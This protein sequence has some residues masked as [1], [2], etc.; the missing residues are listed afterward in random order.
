MSKEKYSELLQPARLTNSR[1]R[2]IVDNYFSDRSRI[3]FSPY[4]RT[5]QQ[6]TQVFP[7][8]M[9]RTVRTRLVH[10]LEVSNIGSH[11]ARK[12]ASSLVDQKMLD[13]ELTEPFILVV[14][15]ACLVHDIGNPPF[16]HFGET[17][18]KEWFYKNCEIYAEKA[19]IYSKRDTDSVSDYEK[20]K[21]D[22]SRFD[23]NQQGIR[24]LTKLRS[25]SVGVPMN[26]TYQTI[27]SAI[28]YPQST[29]DTSQKQKANFFETE[30]P[31]IS[32][33][34]NHLNM[35]YGTRFPLSYIMEAADD[36][37]Y[38]LSDIDDGIEKGIITQEGFINEFQRAW[39]ELYDDTPLPVSLPNEKRTKKELYNFGREISSKW[40]DFLVNKVVEQYTNPEIHERIM[41]G[42]LDVLIDKNSECGFV[43]NT[44][45]SIAKNHLYTADEV[46]NLE[47]AGLKIIRGLLDHFC[48]LLKLDN[49]EFSNLIFS[50]TKVRNGYD[51]ERRVFGKIG[52]RFKRTYIAEIMA[53]RKHQENFEI[54]YRE[55]PKDR[56][57]FLRAHMIIDHIVAM[58]DDYALTQFKLAEGIIS[59]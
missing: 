30:K 58:T 49:D 40:T 33:M 23:G 32:L 10:S 39:K 52:E 12:I 29:G 34:W 14:E 28:K 2:S 55:T 18:I 1:P 25:H 43:L 54:C 20:C 5:L 57:W 13:S 51:I 21:K 44:L 3:L 31:D 42:R 6:K 17:A 26:L 8:E 47:L 53:D 59:V 7:L 24:I 48:V 22:F 35:E 27:L 4:F 46:I 56:E 19:G 16:G 38:C 45:K 41:Q 36:I 50:S 37:A 11:L 9:N 15:N